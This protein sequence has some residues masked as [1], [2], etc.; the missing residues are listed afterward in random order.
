MRTL[1]L[2]SKHLQMSRDVKQTPFS[3]I[4]TAVPLKAWKSWNTLQSDVPPGGSYL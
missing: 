3:L 4:K 1:W 2:Y